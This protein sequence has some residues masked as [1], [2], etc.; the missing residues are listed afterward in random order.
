MSLTVR[1]KPLVTQMRRGQLPKT[2]CRHVRVDGPERPSG[3]NAS[4]SGTTPSN[5]MSPA[6]EPTRGSWT[7]VS[8]GARAHTNRTSNRAHAPPAIRRSTPT[9][10]TARPTRG[11]CTSKRVSA[12]ASPRTLLFATCGADDASG[13]NAVVTVCS[14]ALLSSWRGYVDPAPRARQAPHFD[15]ARSLLAANACALP[16]ATSET[17]ERRLPRRSTSTTCFCWSACSSGR[18]GRSGSPALLSRGARSAGPYGLRSTGRQWALRCAY[19]TSW[20]DLGRQK[21]SRVPRPGPS[22]AENARFKRVV[23]TPPGG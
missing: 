15:P 4:P 17:R 18:L 5:I 22:L 21:K 9:N 16:F 12:H 13:L 7:E 14:Q 8:P 11:P 19:R 2:R 3:R 23:P 6:P 10:R 1:A 20:I